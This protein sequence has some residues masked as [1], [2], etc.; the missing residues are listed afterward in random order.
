MINPANVEDNDIIHLHNGQDQF[1]D[2]GSAVAAAAYNENE[3][4]E[5]ENYD[6]L[7]YEVSFILT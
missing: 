2:G 3:Y 7:G 4:D 6:E 5:D 1:D